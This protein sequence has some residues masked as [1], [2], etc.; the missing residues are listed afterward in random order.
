MAS[1]VTV[2][3]LATNIMTGISVEKR[4]TM[5]NP[6]LSETELASR[7]FTLS[8]CC[9]FNTLINAEPIMLSLIILFSMSMFSRLRLKSVL[10]FLI[11]IKKVT[12]IIGTIAMTVSASYQLMRIS[13]MAVPEII[14]TE[15]MILTKA[16]ETNIFIESISEVRFVNSF[17]GFDLMI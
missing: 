13:K 10:T 1:I 3:K 9:E 12:A 2:A 11:T 5:D 6:I 4:R 16:I 17:D 15:E 14:K 7:N 8:G